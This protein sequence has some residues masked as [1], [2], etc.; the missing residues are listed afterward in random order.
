MAKRLW[1]MAALGLAILG[2]LGAMALPMTPAQSRAPIVVELF[3]S[4]G[5]SSCPPANAIA[6][7]LAERSDLLVLSFGVTYWDQLG[8]RDTFAR[9]DFTKRQ[10]DYAHGLGRDN[11]ATPEMVIN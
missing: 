11:V 8:W 5:C 6:N 9:D 3:Q 4:Q 2:G 1:W 10:Y 7:A